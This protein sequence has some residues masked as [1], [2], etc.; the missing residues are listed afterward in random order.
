LLV[1]VLIV[2]FLFLPSQNLRETLATSL[3]DFMAKIA[4][5]PGVVDKE[6]S[7]NIQRPSV[8]ERHLNVY[9]NLL[10]SIESYGKHTHTPTYI[11][12]YSP[13]FFFFF[14]LFKVNLNMASLVRE[15]LL[16]QFYNSTVLTPLGIEMDQDP[17]WEGELLLKPLTQWYM[18]LINVKC[19]N[20]GAT[21]APTRLAVVN[22]NTTSSSALKF[23]EYAS[24]SELRSLTNLI[25][26]YGIKLIEMEI[27]RYIHKQTLH[28]RD[29][30]TTNK[31][32]LEEFANN[33][34]KETSLVDL[35]KRTRDLDQFL[36]RSIFI[37][38]ALS[39][40]NLLHR[41]LRQVAKEEIPVIYEPVVNLFNQYPRNTSASPEYLAF[42]CLANDI[43]LHSEITE[44]PLKAL[45]GT[46]TSSAEGPL[47]NLLPVAFAAS[48][49]TRV[50]GEAIFRPIT[51]SMPLSL[52]QFLLFPPF[53]APLSP[54]SFSH[55]FLTKWLFVCLLL[56]L[57]SI[58]ERNSELRV[59]DLH[60]D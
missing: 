48:F 12:S 60:V 6:F 46:I 50:W 4:I 52:S 17:T 7:V 30:L 24:L 39:F 10:L 49:T 58:L 31:A 27:L 8:I 59:G 16:G 25:G 28:I 19:Q 34:H 32:A 29:V 3:R 42:D 5:L 26:P 1:L 43:G 54:L 56:L 38:N 57:D 22:N 33:A 36:Q 20:G 2:F 35:L 11:L 14:F 53:L 51:E 40:R 13:T 21:Y 45:L 23:V 44:Q 18:E 37:G 9:I 55:I 15:V 47:W 41:A